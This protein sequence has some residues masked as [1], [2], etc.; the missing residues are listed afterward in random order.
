[1]TYRAVTALPYDHLERATA[2]LRGHLRLIAADDGVTP[3][4][5]TLQVSGPTRSLDG[6][7]HT[8]FEWIATVEGAGKLYPA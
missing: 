7:G 1:M 4:W 2:G 3:D 8:W 6:R 5:S